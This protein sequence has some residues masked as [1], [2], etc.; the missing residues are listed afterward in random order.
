MSPA[1]G[2]L[3]QEDLWGLLAGSIVSSRPMRG[4][5]SKKVGRVAV[6]DASSLHTHKV[7]MCTHTKSESFLANKK[8]SKLIPGE[9]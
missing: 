3:R 9:R 8:S 7:Q 5:T 1:L 4:P 2:R 6:G